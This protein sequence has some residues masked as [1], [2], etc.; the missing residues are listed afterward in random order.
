MECTLN[1]DAFLAALFSMPAE[2]SLRQAFGLG[3]VTPLTG[4]LAAY[5]IGLFINFWNERG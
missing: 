5:L 2:E 3:L 1:A 4:Y